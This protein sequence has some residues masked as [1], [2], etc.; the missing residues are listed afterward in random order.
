MGLFAHLGLAALAGVL[1]S[2]AAQPTMA[3]NDSDR[4]LA[5]LPVRFFSN[6]LEAKM[7]VSFKKPAFAVGVV[8][9]DMRHISTYAEKFNLNTEW[10]VT[11][12]YTTDGDSKTS[13]QIPLG[14]YLPPPSGFEISVDYP[15]FFSIMVYLTYKA[16]QSGKLQVTMAP[17]D[18]KFENQRIRERYREMLEAIY[19][20]EEQ[21]YRFARRYGADYFVYDTGFS[22]GG[23]ESR[24]Y[25]ADKIK[26]L[27][28]NCAAMLIL[29]P[30]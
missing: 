20:N 2:L 26:K 25:K 12:N 28:P 24:R 13:F 16:L 29:S 21:F 14:K 17:V 18:S 6:I 1:T 22:Y 11:L 3:A 5:S 27:D 7:V 30:R 10:K 9:L 19:G 15:E 8:V 23:P 4:L